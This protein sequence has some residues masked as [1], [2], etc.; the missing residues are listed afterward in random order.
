MRPLCTQCPVLENLLRG[1]LSS[2]QLAELTC[3]FHTAHFQKDQVLSFD[4]GD[5]R[6][7]FALYSGTVKISKSF[8]NGKSRITRVVQAGELFGL[9]AL[10]SAKYSMTAVA[11]ENCTVCTASRES[12]L[13]LFRSHP[14]I[15]EA[16]VRCLLGE[17]EQL[18]NQ[19]TRMTGRDARCRVAAFLL[20]L[21]PAE[22]KV[23]PE[24]CTLRLSFSRQ[25]I[26]EMLDI[27]A[28]SVSRA[29]SHLQQ[30][31][32]L[33]ARGRRLLIPNPHRLHALVAS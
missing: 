2:E 19:L 6:H 11:M 18:R 20:S 30:E 33:T 31:G 5:A 27:S 3:V 23:E 4:G 12:F 13:G 1:L 24:P 21:L 9:E 28:E 14:D 8:E 16:L 15:A 29:L 26:G 25:E 32:L 22:R 7:I 10:E 17:I